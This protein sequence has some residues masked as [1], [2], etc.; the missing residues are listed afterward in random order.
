[1]VTSKMTQKKAWDIKNGP[2]GGNILE[3]GIKTN[4]MD[5][6]YFHGKTAENIMGPTFLIKNMDWANFNGPMANNFTDNG[7]MGFRMA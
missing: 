5:K 1:M 2:M 7:K 4:N 3:H 6:V